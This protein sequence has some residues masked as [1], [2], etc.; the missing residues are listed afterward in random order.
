MLHKINFQEIVDAT[1]DGIM[2]IDDKQKIIFANSAAEEIFGYSRGELIGKSHDILAPQQFREKHITL[3]SKYIAQPKTIRRGDIHKGINKG[4]RKDGSIF[5]VDI[6]MTPTKIREE[7]VI[8]CVARD[9]ARQRNAE[10]LIIKNEIYLERLN[11]AIKDGVFTVRL[12]ER[13]IEYVNKAVGRIFGYSRDELIGQSTEIIYANKKE[14]NSFGQKLKQTIEQGKEILQT[15]QLYKRKTGQ[16]F[17]G[18]ITVTFVG[19]GRELRAVGVVEDITERKRAEEARKRLS[20]HNKRILNSLGEGVYG[21]D[22]SGKATFVNPAGAQILGYKVEELIGRPMHA[23]MH[24]SKSDGSPYPREECPIYAAFKDGLTHRVIDEVFWKKDGTSFPVEYISTPIYEHGELEGAVV[25]FTDITERKKAELELEQKRHKLFE[26]NKDMSSFLNVLEIT[27]TS[28]NF[29]ESLNKLLPHIKNLTQSSYCLI[30]L[31]DEKKGVLQPAYHFG[32]SKDKLS[33]FMSMEIKISETK[34]LLSEKEVR[35]FPEVDGISNLSENIKSFLR[36]IGVK[37]LIIIPILYHKKPV[38]YIALPYVETKSFTK[39]DKYNT[40]KLHKHLEAFYLSYRHTQDL[41]NDTMSLT[42]ELEMIEAMSA[43]DGIILSSTTEEEVIFRAVKFFGQ[44][45]PS[46]VIEVMRY[47]PEQKVFNLSVVQEEGRVIINRDEAFDE[48]SIKSWENIMFGI[49]AYYPDISNGIYEAYEKRFRDRLFKSLL[50]LPLLSKGELIGLIA[51]GH[52]QPALYSFKQL[53][54]TQRLSNQI[55]VALS[56]TGLISELQEMIVG[57][58]NSLATALDAKSAW[59][60]GHSKRVSEIAVMIGK[61]WRL[62]DDKLYDLRLAALFHDIGKIG[63]YEGVLD[64]AEKLNDDESAL[65][66]QH[67]MKTYEILAPIPRLENIGKIAKHHHE[68]WDGGGYPDGL[69]GDEI[70]YLS[71]IIALADSYDAM[72]SDRPYRKALSTEQVINEISSLAGK[73]FDS[74][75]AEVFLDILRKEKQK[76]L[77]Q[78]KAA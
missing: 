64:K 76:K 75:I 17:T 42:Q 48:K 9:I 44:V 29:H 5:P 60:Q 67:P 10:N 53:E 65:I 46:D 61:Q 28:L 59:T 51:I 70:P 38:A 73:Q 12:P 33:Y 11:D 25:V 78:R 16:T 6:S 8:I 1:P 4:L 77:S 32:L 26:R 50:I 35:F 45:V 71:R 15:E 24:H 36:A 27:S 40:T 2:A 14:F 19:E 37:S 47:N 72:T 62:N 56:N 54:A 74:E 31:I 18:E 52:R 58:V 49:P 43:I 22:L 41:L 23:T 21:L 57:V 13:R 3:S 30:H 7:P 69:A 68:R 55:A 34:P 63:T 20:H 39:E 66:K